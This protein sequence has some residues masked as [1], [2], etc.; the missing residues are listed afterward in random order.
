VQ[1]DAPGTSLGVQGGALG[2]PRGSPGGAGNAPRGSLGVQGG[3]PGVPWGVQGDPRGA[4]SRD[5]SGWHADVSPAGG[6]WRH[7]GVRI[8][9]PAVSGRPGGGQALGEPDQAARL[10]DFMP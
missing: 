9:L 5:E 4:R 10:L 1:G 6:A 8:P 2:G 7:A 3:P